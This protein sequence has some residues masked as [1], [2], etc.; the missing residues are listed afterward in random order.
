[1]RNAE[2]KRWS[3]ELVDGL[4]KKDHGVWTQFYRDIRPIL[5]AHALSL[6]SN[7][8]DAE[9][10]VQRAIVNIFARF[11]FRPQTDPLPPVMTAVRNEVRM[12]RRKRRVRNE[13]HPLLVADAR[14][15]GDSPEKIVIQ[16]ESITGM[17]RTIG[18][19]DKRV[20]GGMVEDHTDQEIADALGTSVGAIKARKYRLRKTMFEHGIK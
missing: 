19:N 15:I 17:I 1:M 6:T 13:K 18:E 11:K 2:R 4:N 3:P 8:H 16:R 5:Y 9:E 12:E 20:L 14:R 10:V 7:P